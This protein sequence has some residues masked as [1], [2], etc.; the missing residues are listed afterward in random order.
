MHDCDV[1]DDGVLS[2]LMTVALPDS[3]EEEVDV[4]VMLVEH[5]DDNA[6]DDVDRRV[7]VI[8]G[9]TRSSSSSLRGKR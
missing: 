3:D 7:D 2:L 1:D 6:D 9:R 4:E 5:S 8:G